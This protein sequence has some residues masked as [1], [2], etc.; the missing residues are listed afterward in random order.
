MRYDPITA[1]SDLYQMAEVTF[2][3]F[4]GV[5]GEVDERLDALSTLDRIDPGLGSRIGDHG[6]PED[7]PFWL[8]TFAEILEKKGEINIKIVK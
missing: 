7:E 5:R 6:D 1:R 2:P 8:T 3:G 4:T